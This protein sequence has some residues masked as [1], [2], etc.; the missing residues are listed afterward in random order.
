MRGAS[1]NNAE[2]LRRELWLGSS[3][4][5]IDC[6]VKDMTDSHSTVGSWWNL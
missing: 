4:F 6:C 3:V 5:S 2:G 1:A